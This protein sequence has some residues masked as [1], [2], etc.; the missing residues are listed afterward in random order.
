MVINDEVKNGAEQIYMSIQGEH[1][2]NVGVKGFS[3]TGGLTNPDD[4][5]L[6]TT[7]KWTLASASIKDAAGFLI[8]HS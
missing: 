8:E 3:Y 7:S 6:G 2:Y 4:T 5:E 1:A